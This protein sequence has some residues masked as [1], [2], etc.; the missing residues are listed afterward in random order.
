MVPLLTSAQALAIDRRCVDEL[1]PSS[2]LMAT[3]ASNATAEV[4]R[5]MATSSAPLQRVL[6]LCGPG[7]NGGDG[8]A[9]ARLLSSSADVVVL[10]DPPT[11]STSA[12]ATSEYLAA[13][14]LG[15]VTLWDSPDTVELL[16]SDSFDV[17]IDAILG[18][19]ARPGLSDVWIQRLERIRRLRGRRFSIDVATGLDAT[20]GDAH[21][22][23]FRAHHTITMVAPKLGMFL[24]DGP[25]HTGTIHI[26]GIGERRGVTAEVATAFHL[27]DSDIRTL[28]PA[29]ART[30]SKFDYGRVLVLGGSRS[31]RGA[32]SL[33][34]HAAITSGAGIVELVT[35]TLHPLTPREVMT[36]VVPSTADGTMASSSRDVI[37]D[38]LKKA[39]VLVVGPGMGANEE[40]LGMVT[41]VL[42][43]VRPDLPVVLDAD[44]L[45]VFPQLTKRPKQLILTPHLGEMRH[46]VHGS[47]KHHQDLQRRSFDIANSFAKEYGVTVHLKSVPS[48]TT[49]GTASFVTSNGNPGMATAGSGDVLAG[50]IG[51]LLAQHV[52]ALQSA[53]LGAYLHA[54]SAD[55]YVQ[56]YAPETLIASDIIDGLRNVIPR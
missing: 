20:T 37:V 44:G 27:E 36:Y 40:T 22:A 19:G 4:R 7:N 21:P 3:A 41:E 39:T 31:M 52:P 28:L 14:S 11:P 15:I 53:A 46:L 25:H 32:A 9:M 13:T 51:G 23:A 34:A 17:I 48:V 26:V 8:F 33:A 6:V 43:T 10:A 29:R 38:R 16:R 49:D 24:N 45:R 47:D 55:N 35:S 42:E 54:R 1:I 56:R 2:V 18:T 5:C 50:I 30:T 12:E